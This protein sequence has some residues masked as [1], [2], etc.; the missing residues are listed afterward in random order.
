MVDKKLSNNIITATKWSFITNL[1]RKMITPVTNMILARLL[2]PDAFGVVATINIVISFSELFSDAGFQ[3]Y[4]VQH[5]FENERDLYKTATVA[6][7]TNF[8]V[9]VIIWLFI[10]VFRDSIASMVGSK[11][12]GFHLVIASLAIPFAALSSI[13]QAI[14]KR[15]FDF[16]GLFL[17]RL[18]NSIVPIFVTIPLAYSYRNCWALIVGTLLGSISDAVIL[19][20]K[21]KWKPRLY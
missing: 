8:C 9:S 15:S 6:F 4:L 7:W 18:I 14:Y 5:E 21:S 19:T 1:M 13:Q 12:Y 2:T 3:K 16:K 17:P 10:A 20:I 11:G